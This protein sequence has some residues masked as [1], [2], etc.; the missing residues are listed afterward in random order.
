VAIKVILKSK[1]HTKDE[2]DRALFELQLHSKLSHPHIIPFLAGEETNDSVIIV[3]PLARGD[4]RSM[5]A[6]K[7]LV[8]ENCKRL[9]KQLLNALSYIHGLNL[10]HGDIKPENILLFE[11]SSH[12]A[13]YI[14]K[15][16][17][18]GFTEGV[19]E[20]GVL[21]HRGM[22]GS[23]GYFSP[24]QLNKQS[25]GQGVDIF[26]L[27][28]IIFTLL[29]GYEPFYPTNR[30]GLLTGDPSRDSSI[31]VFESPYW[32]SISEDA[33]SFLRGLLHGDPVQRLTAQEALRS[34]WISADRP[35]VAAPKTDVEDAHIQ[36]E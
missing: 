27:G 16:C 36:F 23:L 17:D 33:K 24:E 14:A 31:L 35:Y 15:I 25:Y 4:L 11:S 22:R 32:D 9:C 12:A 7:V 18:F 5:T 19:G 20:S 30:A 8:E 26:A 34:D 21:P 6:N 28:I 1:L 29:C 10:V 2:L 13:K 3:T